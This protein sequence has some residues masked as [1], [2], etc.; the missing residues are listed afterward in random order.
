MKRSLI[1]LL[2]LTAILASFAQV[3][4]TQYLQE[5]ELN[6]TELKALRHQVEALKFKNRSGIYPDN[7]ELEFGHLW[8]NPDELGIRTDFSVSQSFEFPTVYRH[9]SKIAHSKNEQ[10]ELEYQK[11]RKA[12][13]HEANLL[14]IDLI[15]TNA[16]QDEL[17]RRIEHAGSIAQSVSAEFEVGETTILA[18][19]KAKLNLLHISK[20]QSCNQINREAI[21]A[22]L[23]ALNSGVRLE[24]EA[25][26]FLA[27]S[28]P[29]SFED[30]YKDREMDNPELNWLNVETGIADKELK[31]SRAMSAPGLK[32]R[33]SVV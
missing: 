14:I 3:D 5:I 11:K 12:I 27:S 7:P 23:D 8:S 28:I 20:E 6:N 16:V 32:D 10:A 17:N 9:R 18:F 13:L 1:I 22:E 25:S 19:N 31:L 29:L 33:K 26:T 2:L 30:W 15:Y 4:P 24:I 21:I